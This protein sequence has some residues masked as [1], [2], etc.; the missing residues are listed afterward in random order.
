MLVSDEEVG[1]QLSHSAER[2]THTQLMQ[3]LQVVDDTN[4][5]VGMKQQIYRRASIDLHCMHDLSSYIILTKAE[6]S[7][8]S[9]LTQ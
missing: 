9:T 2:H 3:T 5:Q 7:T 6:Q 8:R 1:Q 4:I